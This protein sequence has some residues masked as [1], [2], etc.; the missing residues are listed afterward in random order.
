MLHDFLVESGSERPG[1]V[2]ARVVDAGAGLRIGPSS[3]DVDF[4]GAPVVRARVAN[5]TDHD[6]DALVVATVGD[7][8]GG[9]VRAST[10]V[11]RLPPRSER[12][13]ELWCPTGIVPASVHW[14][15]TPL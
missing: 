9:A 2:D 4:L 13:I 10:F 8:H 3:V 6:V 5:P 15:V 12:Q 11:E 14:S 7:G 1:F